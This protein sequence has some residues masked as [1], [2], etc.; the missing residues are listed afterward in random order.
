MIG[1]LKNLVCANFRILHNSETINIEWGGI[2]V[3]APYFTGTAFHRINSSHAFS[4][5]FCIIFRVFAIDQNQA[6]MTGILKRSDLGNQV[7][8]VECNSFNA[9]IGGFESAICTV[10]G[11]TISNV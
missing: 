1:F 5:K 4:N 9:F 7:V 6:F 2:N 10:I 3:D 11:T 8:M